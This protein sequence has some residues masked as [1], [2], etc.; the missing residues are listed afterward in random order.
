[1]AC[2][3]N[4]PFRE[5]YFQRVAKE[6]ERKFL[7]RKVPALAGSRRS[8]DIAQG[9]LAIDDGTEVRVRRAGQDRFVTVK[10]G[11][12]EI[13]EEI[14]IAIGEEQFA[15]LWPLT[16]ARRLRKRRL[17]VTL[18]RGLK[19]ELDVFRGALDGLLIAEVEFSSETASREFEPPAWFGEEITGDHRYSGQSLARDGKP[20]GRAAGPSRG[21]RLKAKEAPAAGIE[22]I[23]V[24]RAEKA[25]EALRHARAGD[26]VADSIH[27]ARKD[28]KKLRSALRLV[29]P[30]IDEE[31]FRSEN[32]RYRDAGR[33]LSSSRDAEVK[34]ETLDALGER[35]GAEL[36]GRAL[37]TWAGL[38]AAERDELGDEDAIA[39][40]VESAIGA[41]E[42]GREEI[43]RW[44]P[45]NGSWDLFAPGFE[46]TYKRGRRELKRVRAKRRA[47]DV[48]QWRKRVKDLWYQLRILRKAWPELLGET[49]DQA[50]RLADL[51]GD[52]HDLTVL[53]EDLESRPRLADEKA[54]AR[55]IERRQ[56]ELLDEAL[57]LGARLYAEKPKALLR[58]LSV[59]W[60][61]WRGS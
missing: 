29:R 30:A 35:F 8:V 17:A 19:V 32:S 54:L 15:A 14:E 18:E 39:G 23:A 34:L 40:Q 59:Y 21:Y 7:L 5:R 56:D 57:E 52:H 43:A 33:R 45:S 53:R 24:A 49:A 12:G 41:I 47:E 48:H 51:L 1:M 4:A 55:A 25:L 22:R 42:A 28:L 26:R 2:D 37:R 13:R 61:T 20:R 16:D 36:S 38:L 58:R 11:R 3:G 44:R 46:R 9:Y 6:I 60:K 50:H 31:R 27:S 10:S